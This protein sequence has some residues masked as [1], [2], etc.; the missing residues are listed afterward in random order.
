MDALK[1]TLAVQ[2]SEHFEM[3]NKLEPA[4]KHDLYLLDPYSKITSIWGSLAQSYFLK[5]QLDSAKWAFT[6]G[7]KR[8]GFIEAILDFNRQ[9]LNTCEK[10]AI[11]FTFGDNVTFPIWY[12]QEI[13]QF[14][15]DINPIDVNLVNAKWYPRYLIHSKGIKAD[16]S[17]REIDSLDYLQWS[18][19]QIVIQDQ[20]DSTRKVSWELKP[21][22]LNSY[23]LRGDIFLL[24]ILRNNFFSRPIYFSN[25]S[26]STYNLYLT[27]HLVDKGLASLVWVNKIDG[28]KDT[29]Y[30]NPQLANY[31]LPRLKYSELIKSKD[32]V[33][34]L[35]MFRWAYHSNIVH[36]L[37]IGK[38]DL[39]KNLFTEMQ[40]KFPKQ[41]LP[42][43]NEEEEKY[44][45]DLQASLFK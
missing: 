10:N 5:G 44:F 12:L 1:V 42:F 4:Y 23:I 40:I 32:A 36:L 8:G 37:G 15:R 20:G 29:Q 43:T 17:D 7:K 28:L 9:L 26:D 18:T 16:I 11:L 27:E 45:N 6:E 2:A 33:T 34:V 41:K 39:A 24:S 19:K 21:T 13:E 3:V 30:I 35:S 31:S 25:Y 38:N 14:R 22:Y